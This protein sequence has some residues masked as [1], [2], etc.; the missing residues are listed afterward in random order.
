[1]ADPINPNDPYRPNPADDEMTRRSARLDELQPD[2][3]L[4]EA[5]ANGGRIAMVALGIAVILGAVFYGLNG[6]AVNP[7][8][9]SKSATQSAPA[10]Q[11][12]AQTTPRTP[13]NNIAD[14]KP[15]VAP[16]IRDVTPSNNQNNQPGV[17]TGAAPSRPQP[18]AN[19][20]TGAEVDSAKGGARN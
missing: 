9:T 2:P 3:Q 17:T 18:P 20:P 13:T 1:M 19:A 15:P 14:S 10:R 5:P 11:D 7:A 6:G 8:D 4:A 12:S 16:G